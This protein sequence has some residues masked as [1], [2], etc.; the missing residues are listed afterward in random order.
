M[1]GIR[2]CV[3]TGMQASMDL[4]ATGPEGWGG[5]SFITTVQRASID[6]SN[7]GSEG[8]RHAAG[9]AGDEWSSPAISLRA[10]RAVG[11]LPAAPGCYVLVLHLGGPRPQTLTVGCLGSWP[12]LPGTYAYC[13]SAHGPGGLRARVRRHL[14]RDKPLHWHIDYLAAVA[15][16]VAIWL[17]PGA[18]RAQECAIAGHLARRPG[19]YHPVPGFG[20]SD[21]RCPGHLIALPGDP[22]P[23]SERLVREPRLANARLC[24]DSGFFPDALWS[25]RRQESP[26]SGKTPC[27]ARSAC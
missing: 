16:V 23:G 26:A 15:E 20:S 24:P 18:P 3:L 10:A 7:T 4:S 13:G 19:A 22:W 21:C 6:L 5:L 2:Y 11:A 17:W 8:A 27:R 9:E 1:K 14:R 25:D 12:F